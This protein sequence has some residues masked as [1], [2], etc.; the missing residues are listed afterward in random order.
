MVT[1]KTQQSLALI[2][3]ATIMPAPAEVDLNTAA[4]YEAKIKKAICIPLKL[5]AA[6]ACLAG[7]CIGADICINY[8]RDMKGLA[9]LFDDS[10]GRL[11]YLKYGSK[12]RLLALGSALPLVF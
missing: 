9:P 3:N 4:S 8:N 12:A 1:I 11:L 2:T 5:S 6:A 7:L 10:L